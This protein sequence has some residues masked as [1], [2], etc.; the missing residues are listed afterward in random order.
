MRAALSDVPAGQAVAVALSAGADSAMLALA[1]AAAAVDRPLLAF[2]VH[3]GLQAQADEWAAHARRLGDLLGI[4][5]RVVQVTVPMD[6]SGMEAAARAARYA[7][8]ADAARRDGVSHVLLAHHQDDQAETVLLRLLRGSGVDGMAAMRASSQRDGVTYLRPWLDLNRQEIRRAATAFAELTGWQAV[9]D[10]SNADPRYTRAAVRTALSPL[11]DARWPG[12]QA[13]VARHARQM[14]EAAQILHEVAGEDFARLQPD[15]DG[16]GFGL[17]AWREL[18]PPRQAQ[19]LRYWLAQAGLRMPAESRL[20]ELMR[21]L[22]QLHAL[23]HDRQ[24]RVRHEG[25]EI[26]CHR[27]RVWLEI[28]PGPVDAAPR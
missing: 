2:H 28:A 16:R 10:P 12:W 26:R 27:G 4:A 5:V 18:S 23:G 7:A 21:Q 19:V 24:L 1:A 9:E 17:A 22:R 13:I 3:H 11:L 20:A 25:H 15:A 8:L 6:G 14:G